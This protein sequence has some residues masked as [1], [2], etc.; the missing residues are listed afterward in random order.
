MEKLKNM[1][2]ALDEIASR[3]G[4]GFLADRETI[5]HRYGQNTGENGLAI[6]IL[7]IFG[8]VLATLAFAAFLGYLDI[9]DSKAAILGLGIILLLLSLGIQRMFNA[10]VLDSLG[11][12]LYIL[13]MA[14]LIFGMGQFDIHG[15]SIVLLVSLLALGSLP[16]SKNYVLNFISML[17]LAGALLYLILENELPDLIHVY[18]IFYTLALAFCMLQEAKFL[19]A[20]PLLSR[21]HGPLR[22]GLVFSLLIGL[23]T[24]G[25]TGLA[26]KGT[27]H[28]W[29]SALAP[30]AIILGLIPSITKTLGTPPRNRNLIYILAA[31]TLLPTL[32]APAI[33]GSLLLVLLSFMV[34]YRTG[35]ALGAIALACFTIQFYYD[36]NLDL[37]TKSILLLAS[38]LLFLACHLLF[39]LKNRSHEEV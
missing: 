6:K 19:A 8:G 32:F 18:V 29:I 23:G 27:G 20:R 2:R 16:L 1:E 36:L 12:S 31:L 15:N 39:T 28:L 3:E 22:I 26:P 9:F 14:M 4:G 7:S 10:L 13:G 37:L 5:L 38:G 17:I 21:L 34:N 35:S 24:I 25:A 30:V 33:A 11:I